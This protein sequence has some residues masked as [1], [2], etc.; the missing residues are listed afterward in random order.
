MYRIAITGPEST[1]KTTLAEQLAVRTG[2]TLAEDYSRRYIAE[3]SAAYSQA[4]VLKIAEG[5]IALED[6]MI[7]HGGKAMLS[8][9]DLINIKVW[10]K[11]YSWEVPLWLEKAI[12]SRRF[13]LYL[14]CYPDLPWEPDPQRQNPYD[15]NHLF[16]QFERELK[17]VNASYAIIRG[18]NE[19]RLE[20]ALK[21]ITPLI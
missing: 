18:A 6:A 21:I 15:R 9:N 4:D 11:Y 2:L 1:G 8:D 16:D 19:N 3:L 13:D 5:I 10:L 20:N 17:A 7:N 14:L 12:V